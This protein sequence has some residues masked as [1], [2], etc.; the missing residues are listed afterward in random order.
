M[1]RKLMCQLLPKTGPDT[2]LRYTLKTHLDQLGADVTV[3]KRVSATVAPNLMQAL[4]GPKEWEEYETKKK[5]IWAAECSC[6]VCNETYY[7]DWVSEAGQKGIGLIEGPDGCTYPSL[8][9][10][11]PGEGTYIEI[12]QNDGFL[13]PYCA[14]VTVLRHASSLRGGRTWK[15]CM[16]SVENVGI[17][18]TVFYWLVT[19]Q[20]DEC[21]CEFHDIRPWQAYVLDEG[22]RLNRFIFNQYEESWRYSTAQGDAFFSKYPSSDG[23]MY[24]YRYGGYTFNELPSLVGCT[25]E[26]TGLHGYVSAGGRMPLLYLKTWRRHKTVEN[27]ITAGWCELVKDDLERESNGGNLEIPHAIMPGVFFGG[28]R[29]HEM[30]HM[31]KASFRTLRKI[32]PEGWSLTQYEAWLNYREDGGA[33]N[34]FMFDAYYSTFGLSGTNTLLELRKIMPEI[35]F[36]KLENYLKKQKLRNEEAG[37]LLDTWKMTIRLFGRTQLTSEELWPRNLFDTHERMS[38]Q[39]RLE[40]NKDDWTKFLE[41]FVAVRNRLRDLE[42]TDGELCVVLPKDNG[43][44][45]REG[46]VLRHCVH[47]YGADHVSGKHTIFFIRKY[48]RPERCYYT[49]DINMTGKPVRQ[50]LHGYGNERHGPHKEYSHSIPQKVQAFCDRWQNEILM[51]WYREQLR[52][53]AEQ[54]SHDIRKEAKT[55]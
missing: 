24:N 44:L 42:W 9:D 26:K 36:P 17:Y 39:Y 6:T 43:D 3:F 16:A 30:L 21:G 20:L 32:R 8:D 35:D 40:N 28:K 48:R 33:A 45:I 4:M 34:A 18:T 2:V 37:M 51:P 46:D 31:D 15:L 11:D 23:G 13:C 38:R 50:Q 7:T 27:L 41:G 22:G 52:K 14:A 5:T 12:G 55:A 54:A 19:R 10:Y 25:G 49:L 47:S 1:D 53:K 29:P